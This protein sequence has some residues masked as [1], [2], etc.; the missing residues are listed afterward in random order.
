MKD[1]TQDKEASGEISLVEQVMNGKPEF[2]SREEAINAYTEKL[3]ALSKKCGRSIPDM[4]NFAEH[5]P[6]FDEDCETA[7]SL[8]MTLSFLKRK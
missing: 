2:A 3:E 1:L 5:S 6:E 8:W 4:L 7:M